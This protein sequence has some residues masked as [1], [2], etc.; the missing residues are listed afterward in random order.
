MNHASEEI[1]YVIP[2]A[3]GWIVQVGAGGRKVICT[4][5]SEVMRAVGAAIG[6]ILRKGGAAS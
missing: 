5:Q 2:T 6:L 1:V 3:D 4:K